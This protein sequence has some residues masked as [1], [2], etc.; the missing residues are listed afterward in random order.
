MKQNKKSCGLLME[1]VR[2]PNNLTTGVDSFCLTT[3][4]LKVS[5]LFLLSLRILGFES[6][7]CSDI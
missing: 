1:N 6:L 7:R 2:S 4:D 3:W 5:I